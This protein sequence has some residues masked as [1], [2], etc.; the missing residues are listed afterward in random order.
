MVSTSRQFDGFLCFAPSDQQLDS[1][2]FYIPSVSAST[3]DVE[4]AVELQKSLHSYIKGVSG[5]KREALIHHIKEMSEKISSTISAMKLSGQSTEEIRKKVK[6]MHQELRSTSEKFCDGCK[7]WS[8][9]RVEL[10]QSLSDFDAKIRA[11]QPRVTLRDRSIGSHSH[12]HDSEKDASSP[13]IAHTAIEIGH[14][15]GIH[16]LEHFLPKPKVVMIDLLS[17]VLLYS[18]QHH[19]SPWRDSVISPGTTVAITEALSFVVPGKLPAFAVLAGAETLALGAKYAKPYVDRL[20][21]DPRLAPLWD[22]HAS[23]TAEDGISFPGAVGASQLAL[24]IAPVPAEIIHAIHQ[25]ITDS[26]SEFGDHL[27]ITDATIAEIAKRSL[28]L[29]AINSTKDQWSK[30][31]G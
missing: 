14:G 5:Q 1:Q 2:S 6:S 13:G 7:K 3:E 12:F 22:L 9:A 8:E 15:I 27:G 21:K 17:K 29:I 18:E 30:F 25:K 23:S 4:E 31:V 24:Q 20:E 19:T 28:E 11:S 10:F 26:V 16:K